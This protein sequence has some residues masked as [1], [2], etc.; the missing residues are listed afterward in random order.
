M[1]RTLNG[2]YWF[3]DNKSK[4]SRFENAIYEASEKRCRCP[5]E[6]PHFYSENAERYGC[7]ADNQI[8]DSKEKL[9]MVLYSFFDNASIF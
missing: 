8:D 9:S 6:F 1:T 7:Y 2:D 5:H 4:C 3:S